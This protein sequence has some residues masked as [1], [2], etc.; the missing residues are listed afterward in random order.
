MVHIY[1][2]VKCGAENAKGMGPYIEKIENNTS[3]SY[4]ERNN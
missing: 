1:D 3:I 2:N 4:Y